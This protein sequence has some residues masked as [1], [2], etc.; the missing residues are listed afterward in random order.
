MF[1][2]C[3][4]GDKDKSRSKNVHKSHTSSRH[5]AKED[6]KK[7]HAVD[8]D[9][10]KKKKLSVCDSVTQ[11]QLFLCS[12]TWCIFKAFWMAGTAGFVS[13]FQKQRWEWLKRDRVRIKN[14]CNLFRFI[15]E[16]QVCAEE[17]SGLHK[18]SGRGK[19]AE[20]DVRS[21]PGFFFSLRYFGHL[22]DI[23][24]KLSFFRF[25]MFFYYW[26]SIMIE[27]TSFF[28]HFP[29]KFGQWPKN[30][31]LQHK[32]LVPRTNQHDDTLQENTWL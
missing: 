30:R 26:K 20:K 16:C 11:V 3:L 2:A 14:E 24:L 18:T 23:T 15:S 22:S 17:I 28:Q 19:M 10:V 25:R 8:N 32:F 7:S 21:P 12:C 27:L 6:T 31:S 5:E 29:N 4:S 9:S 1:C 13:C